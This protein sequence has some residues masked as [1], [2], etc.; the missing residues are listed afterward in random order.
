MLGFLTYEAVVFLAQKRLAALRDALA[1]KINDGVAVNQIDRQVHHLAKKACEF[2]AAAPK[3]DVAL[4][5]TSFAPWVI[6]DVS[7]F[8]MLG[9]LGPEIPRY[10]GL[11][12]QGQ[13]WLFDTIHNGN[14]D[15]DLARVRAG[16]TDLALEIFTRA[17]AAVDSGGGTDTEKTEKRNRVR[18]FTLGHLC[19]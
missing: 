18:A 7:R 9:G 17:N 10:S 3:V 12:A 13:R 16:S 19:H 5:A 15:P 1:A 4:P 2:L 8:A 11:L 6:D 14:P